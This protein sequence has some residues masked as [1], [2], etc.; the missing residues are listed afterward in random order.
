MHRIDD[1]YRQG[2][3]HGKPGSTREELAVQL[4]GS[5]RRDGMAAALKLGKSL[6]GADKRLLLMH[7]LVAAMQGNLGDAYHLQRLARG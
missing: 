7:A 6:P 4:M 5:Y 2:G 1:K 3:E